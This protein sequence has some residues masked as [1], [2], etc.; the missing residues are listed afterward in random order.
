[1]DA[2]FEVINQELQQEHDVRNKL[3][4]LVKLLQENNRKLT[5]V[6]QQIHSD[7]NKVN[8]IIHKAK[9]LLKEQRNTYVKLAEQAQ[10]ETR[11]KFSSLWKN[12]AQKD[13][14]VYT[15]ITWLETGKLASLEETQNFVFG[16]QGIPVELENYLVGVTFLTP[17]LSRLCVNA[18]IAADYER[19]K[20]IVEFVKDLYNGFQLL[21]LR[22]DFL[23]KRFDGMK[24]DLKK[25]EEVNLEVSLRGLG[26]KTTLSE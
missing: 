26:K 25:I 7:Y 2:I 1:M 3:K 16:S 20:K 11:F 17:E 6:C 15:F 10:G 5:V 13:V 21:N 8:D 12:I 24:Y 22:N 9:E 4:E 18:V 23:R 19:P 14:F